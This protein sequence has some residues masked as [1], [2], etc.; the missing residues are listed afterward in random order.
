MIKSRLLALTVVALG[1][2]AAL[3][4]CGGGDDSSKTPA[5]AEITFDNWDAFVSS[6]ELDQV[7]PGQVVIIGID[8]APWKFVDQLIDE[9]RLPNLARI[10]K[11]GAR[12]ILRSTQ[13]YVT[14]PAWTSVFTGYP[15][16]QTGIYSFGQW[17]R[18]SGE[19]I[20]VNSD[21]VKVPFV[22][23]AAS[24]SGL[25]VGVFNVP[26]TYPAHPVNGNV[27]SG[28][29][30][31]I[32]AADATNVIPFSARRWAKSFQADPTIVNYSPPMRAVLGD[33][34]NAFLF[35]IHD[36][37]DDNAPNYDRVSLR[38]LSRVRADARAP[39]IV[40]LSIRKDKDDPDMWVVGT[41]GDYRCDYWNIM[42]PHRKTIRKLEGSYRNGHIRDGVFMAWGEGIRGGYDAG[43]KEIADVAPTILYIAGLP[44]APDMTGRGMDDIFKPGFL[45]IRPRF[46]NAGYRDIPKMLM[47]ETEGRESLRKKLRSLGYIR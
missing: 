17:D 20:T 8:G 39:E 11:E 31:P 30:T 35:L 6:E 21:D 36:S 15:P 47:L 19:F 10:K 46:V 5:V 18:A 22:W 29:M 4:G 1:V 41:Y 26:M 42:T 45:K 13:S 7:R 38:V 24:R 16:E 9:G 33:S 2:V 34:A 27:V 25:K 32:E 23:E 40:F 28:I 43:R 44:V 3:M 37:T 14:P 12:A